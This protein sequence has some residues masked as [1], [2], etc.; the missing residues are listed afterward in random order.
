MDCL[1]H[2]ESRKVRTRGLLG[3]QELVEL[4]ITE[5]QRLEVEAEARLC[6]DWLPSPL[7]APVRD[8]AQLRKSRDRSPV[9]CFWR[10]TISSWLGAPLYRR[11]TFVSRLSRTFR[12]FPA[13]LGLYSEPCSL[14]FPGKC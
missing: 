2:Q 14:S 12:K 10:M 4:A 8:Q 13:T 7:G 11:G 9:W 5:Q 3:E 6:V 1:V